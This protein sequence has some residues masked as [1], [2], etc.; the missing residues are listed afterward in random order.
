M[1][2]VLVVDDEEHIRELVTVYLTA[3]GFDV[4]QAVDGP[5]GFSAFESAAPDLLVLDLMIPGFDGRELCRRVREVSSVPVLM[6]TAR[7]ADIDKVALLEGG[8]D[9]YVVKP[10]SPPEL[11]ARVRALLRRA[12]P[13]TPSAGSGEPR[14]CVP[15][16]QLDSDAREVRVDGVPVSLTAREFDILAVM[17]ARPGVVFARDRLLEA[18][19][20]YADYVD[21]RG[22]D[23]HIRHLR[24]K[25]G[26]TGAEHR[27]IETVRGVGYRVRRGPQ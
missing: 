27:F 8:A 22:V 25:L 11:V 18:V 9:D 1:P 6:L 19:V 20:G 12:A 2:T 13:P 3:A 14:A 4:V 26:D 16:L 24:E 23:V 17:A 7:D 21:V 5:S 10:F 15:G